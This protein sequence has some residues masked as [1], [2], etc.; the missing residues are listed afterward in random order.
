MKDRWMQTRKIMWATLAADVKNLKENEL[1]SFP[2]D[3]ENTAEFSDE[4][5]QAL[6]E[7]VEKIKE[8]Y[9]A[10]DAKEETAKT[11]KWNLK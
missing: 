11:E 1:L 3:A 8:F 7:E 2:W 9:D 5:H 6:L 4:E 10:L